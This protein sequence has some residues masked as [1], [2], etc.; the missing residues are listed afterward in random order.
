[1]SKVLK[2]DDAV[3]RNLLRAREQL[4]H[5]QAMRAIDEAGPLV[6]KHVPTDEEVTADAL[7]LMARLAAL[8]KPEDK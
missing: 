2:G 1:M 6:D 8:G 4:R 3:L 7:A 5:S